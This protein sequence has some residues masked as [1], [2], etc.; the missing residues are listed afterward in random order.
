MVLKVSINYLVVSTSFVGFVV[1]RKDYYFVVIMANKDYYFVVIQIHLVD[2]KDLNYYLIG[3]AHH[4]MRTIV[5][6]IKI[7]FVKYYLP[8]IFLLI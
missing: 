3:L 7:H 8:L 5:L 4:I 2:Y 6:K 1:I